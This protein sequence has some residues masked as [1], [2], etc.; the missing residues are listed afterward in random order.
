[1]SLLLRLPKPTTCRKGKIC[2]VCFM[3]IKVGDIY[4]KYDDMKMWFSMHRECYNIHILKSIET[5]QGINNM[6]KVEV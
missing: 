6:S 1:M 5:L 4:Y 3:N 2:D